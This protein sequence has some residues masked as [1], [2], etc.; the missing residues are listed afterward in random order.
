MKKNRAEEMHRE[1]TEVDG[2]RSLSP[3]GPT[4]PLR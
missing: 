1:P 3:R 2:R 4:T